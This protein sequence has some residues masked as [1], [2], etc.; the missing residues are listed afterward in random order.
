MNLWPRFAQATPVV[1]EPIKGFEH[2][3]FRKP[4]HEPFHKPHRFLVFV[5]LMF[6]CRNHTLIPYACLKSPRFDSRRGKYPYALIPRRYRARRS[7]NAYLFAPMISALGSMP[8][9]DSKAPRLR[10]C[11]NIATGATDS[12]RGSQVGSNVISQ[13]DFLCHVFTFPPRGPLRPSA[14]SVKAIGLSAIPNGGSVTTIAASS[15]LIISRAV[16]K[17]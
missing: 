3:P 7:D 8:T 4:G 16:S 13:S 17:I 11:P 14:L 5:I 12:A 2:G 9:A 1:P 10:Q 6:P 15:P